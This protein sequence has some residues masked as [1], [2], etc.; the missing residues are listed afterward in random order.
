MIV[1]HPTGNQNVRNAALAF[2]RANFLERFYTT[3]AWQGDSRLEKLLPRSIL[4][5]LRRREYGMLPK[6]KI[7]TYP[8]IE[9]CRLLA[10][11]LGINALTRH[12][13]GLCCIDAVYHNLDNHVARE[14]AKMMPV[15]GVYAY[16]DGALKTF[17]TAKK[18]GIKLNYEIASAYWRAAVTIFREEAELNPEW[19]VTI[20]ALNYSQD[21]LNRKDEEIAL[22]DK[23]IVA[24]NFTATNLALGKF[25][26]KSVSI[27]PYGS[28]VPVSD[29]NFVKNN[30]RKLR[31]LFVGGLTQ[32]KGLSYLFGAKHLLK[33]KISLTVI[34][35]RNRE[36]PPL[37]R[38]LD[39]CRYIPSL[40]HNEVLKQMRSHDVLV[41]PS[42]W[43]GFG[44]VILEAMSQGIP[45]IASTNT[46]GPDVITEG[47]D[48]YIVPIRSS[49]AIAEKLELLANDRELLDR[50]KNSALET[51]RQYSW[52]RYQAALVKN[53]VQ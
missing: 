51:A 12:E 7:S 18:M 37:D 32:G 6:E 23:I 27:I 48:G 31:V 41:F 24:S 21:K 34:G 29:I 26:N 4:A 3:V 9:A 25:L 14:L 15:K 42:L 13:T 16:E 35:R 49:E 43:D 47:E 19:A 20:G 30:S 28:P 17:Q 36:C 8:K 40:P 44:L 52:E 1:S 39:T 2:H 38:Q 53:V 33:D 45:V 5:T 10:I 22:A 50:M 11:I 46:G